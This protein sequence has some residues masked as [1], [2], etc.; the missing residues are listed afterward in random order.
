MP[1]DLDLDTQ[2]VRL[3][4]PRSAALKMDFPVRP[5]LSCVGVAPAGDFAPTSSSAGSYGGNLD[6]NEVREVDGALLRG[7]GGGPAGAC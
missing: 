6:C 4:A 3:R 7:Q 5:M 1:W 2:M